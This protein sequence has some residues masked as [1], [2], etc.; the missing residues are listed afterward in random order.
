M[1]PRTKHSNLD[2]QMQIN[3]NNDLPQILY[4]QDQDLDTRSFS[5]KPGFEYE[6]EVTANGKV[7]T[8]GFR[9]LSLEVRK[10]RLEEEIDAQSIFKQYSQKNCRY[11][12]YPFC[13]NTLPSS[14]LIMTRF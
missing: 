8:P 1:I 3:D 5:L 9:E 14:V 10:C 4:S 11:F 13:K 6:I 2:V 12:L 7:S